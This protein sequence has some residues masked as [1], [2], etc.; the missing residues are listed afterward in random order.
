MH[1]PSVLFVLIKICSKNVNVRLNL[2]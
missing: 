1:L 2:F